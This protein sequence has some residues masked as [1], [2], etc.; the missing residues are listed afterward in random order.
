M[1]SVS[2][3]RVF[4]FINHVSK[5]SMYQHIPYTSI[6]RCKSTNAD[7]KIVLSVQEWKERLTSEEYRVL[8][9]KGT[10]YPDTGEYNTF[11]P[12]NGY[13]VCRGCDNPLY[14]Y[15][16]KFESGCG[17]PAFDKC[18]KDSVKAERDSDGWRIEILCNKCDGHLGHVFLDEGFDTAGKSRSDQRHCV[19][20]ISV[21]YIDDNMSNNLM[22]DILDLE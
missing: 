5:L 19:N 15:K 3:Y 18:F 16:A 21:K 11:K 8:R 20:S 4:K 10:E 12:K 9:N 17:W 7:D 14:S 2:H 13:F 1:R 22:E 6:L